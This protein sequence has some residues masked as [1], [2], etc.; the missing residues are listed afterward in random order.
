VFW[1]FCVGNGAYWVYTNEPAHAFLFG[2]M[3]ALALLV[4][5]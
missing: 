3:L 2:L 4:D 5:K 1:F